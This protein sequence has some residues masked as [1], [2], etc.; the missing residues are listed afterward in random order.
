MGPRVVCFGL[1]SPA[2]G[3]GG[4]SCGFTI[5]K[6][7]MGWHFRV[8]RV[9]WRYGA[10]LCRLRVRTG[11]QAWGS[12]GSRARAQGF[13]LRVKVQG[14]PRSPQGTSRSPGRPRQH[15]GGA[16][17]TQE[18]HRAPRE[19]PGASGEPPRHPQEPQGGPGSPQEAQAA[20]RIPREP[21]GRPQEPQERQG[22]P[23]SPQEPQGA[24][25]ELREGVRERHVEVRGSR[26][27]VEVRG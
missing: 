24:P 25:R 8:P 20:P 11:A 23:G 15:P 19:A 17:S 2:E 5:K 7:P 16:G 6:L 10:Q 14:G 22:G 13:K 3:V 4:P 27:R 9:Q 26:L 12:W 21:P 1:R 18:P